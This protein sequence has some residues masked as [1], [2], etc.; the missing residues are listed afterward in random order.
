VGRVRARHLVPRHL[1]IASKSCDLGDRPEPTLAGPP[2]R[3]PE[4]ASWPGSRTSSTSWSATRDGLQSTSNVSL[5]TKVRT[6]DS[7]VRGVPGARKSRGFRSIRRFLFAAGREGRACP[8]FVILSATLKAA[9]GRPIRPCWSRT[10]LQISIASLRCPRV[11]VARHDGTSRCSARAERL[12]R[13]SRPP[14]EKESRRGRAPGSSLRAVFWVVF[15]TRP[16]GL[17][18]EPAARRILHGATIWPAKHARPTSSTPAIRRTPRAR[19]RA[20][21]STARSFSRGRVSLV[22]KKLQLT[23]AIAVF[24]LSSTCVGFGHVPWFALGSTWARRGLLA[25]REIR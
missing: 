18:P 5:D 22:R 6:Q 12:R 2:G 1:P 4:T 25:S 20:R 11:L 9:W 15:Q 8:A 19:L 10:L 7:H 23:R 13:P 16:S 14:C 17:L 24:G 3:L 21:P